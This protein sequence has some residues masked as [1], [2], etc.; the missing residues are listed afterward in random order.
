MRRLLILTVVVLSVFAGCSDSHK[1][2]ISFDKMAVIMADLN[3]TDKMVREFPMVE[4]DSI[5][6]VLV[7]SLLK[8]HNVSQEEL[9]INLYLYQA[10]YETYERLLKKIRE[11]YE[12]KS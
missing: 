4:R 2:T 8:V 5:G 3:L 1:R 11:N 9:D 10:D 7:K 6:E 12:A